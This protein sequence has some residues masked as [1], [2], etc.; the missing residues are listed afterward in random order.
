[1]GAQLSAGKQT[2]DALEARLPFLAQ[3]DSETAHLL[4]ASIAEVIADVGGPQ[5][6]A[7]ILY[8]S[9]ARGE[10]RPLRDPYPSDVD[11][12]LVFGQKQELNYHARARVFAAL[13]RAESRWLHAPR[14]V[15]V[16][17]ATQTLA[18]WDDEFIASVARDGRL[19]WARSQP[20][21]VPPQ[22]ARVAH[23]PLGAV[24]SV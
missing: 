5:L 8:G 12:L 10:E 9:V 16:M 23:R 13:G 7:A 20:P 17:L 24:M 15:R 3:L 19:L 18:E 1:M 21:D 4:R 14:E 22:L 6:V 11:V 2:I